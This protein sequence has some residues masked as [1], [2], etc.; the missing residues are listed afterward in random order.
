[1]TLSCQVLA[2]QLEAFQASEHR[3]SHMLGIEELLSQRHR[4]ILLRIGEF[5]VPA[6][7]KLVIHTLPGDLIGDRIGSMR[8]ARM[9]TPEG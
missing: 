8:Y 1:M 5:E 7:P 6:I 2:A 9:I 3:D 4:V